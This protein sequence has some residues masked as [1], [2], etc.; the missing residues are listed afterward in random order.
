VDGIRLVAIAEPVEGAGSVGDAGPVSTGRPRIAKGEGTRNRTAGGIL[1]G[2]AAS[3]RAD[4]DVMDRVMTSRLDRIGAAVRWGIGAG[5]D[6]ASAT[7]HAALALWSA[8][9]R[10]TELGFATGDPWRD[11]LLVDLGLALAALLDDL[12]PR[13]AEIA[14]LILVDGARQAEVAAALGVSRATVSVAVARGRLPAIAAARRAIESL[15]V[16][17][18]VPRSGRGADGASGSGSR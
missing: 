3:S 11:A 4:A 10:G 15:L 12:T 9:D 1:H 7:T 5:G 18:P 8:R 2:P 6:D 16:G 17:P 13:Q 14:G